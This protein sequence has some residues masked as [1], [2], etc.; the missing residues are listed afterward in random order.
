[1]SDYK[2]W[3]RIYLTKNIGPVT[4]GG[5]YRKYKDPQRI[6]DLIQK[7]KQYIIPSEPYIDSIINDIHKFGAECIFCVDAQYSQ[8][9]KEIYDLPAFIFVKGN[10]ELLNTEAIA[11]VGARNSSIN[12]NK[13]SQN[14]A[15]GL[16]EYGY[17]IVSGMARG[18]DRHAHIGGMKS[19][20]C[21][22]G[23]GLDVI[24]P[25]DNR[26]IYHD[27]L[28]ND[29]LHVTESILGI[30]P[31]PALF[32]SRNRIIAGIA[33]SILVIEASKNSGSLITA[34]YGM[35]YNRDIFVVPGSPM[36]GRSCG[37]NMLIQ[38]GAYLVQD[39]KE[40]IHETNLFAKQCNDIHVQEELIYTSVQ[41][42]ILD[43][44]GTGSVHINELSSSL[45]T[46]VN[47]LNQILTLMEIDGSIE[48]VSPSRFRRL[49]YMK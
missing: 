38:N 10:K 12:G 39:Y 37:S 47:S 32:P 26:D 46:K 23:N 28:S 3:L 27:V 42:E 40:I 2:D 16:S 45:S 41:E 19:T 9:L 36:D 43:L 13:M 6:I 44:I 18:I 35:E 20:I 14:F 1:M 25:H 34:N 17:T 31:S 30:H 49:V 8:K 22:F 7:Q 4:F 29:G 21:V 11:I 33:N 15:S 5:L 48:Q 24:Y